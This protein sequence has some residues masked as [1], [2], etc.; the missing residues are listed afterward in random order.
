MHSYQTPGTHS[1]SLTEG[2]AYP[3]EGGRVE[4]G[5]GIGSEIQV[6]LAGRK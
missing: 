5:Q 3:G 6:D 4:L 1:L 2:S